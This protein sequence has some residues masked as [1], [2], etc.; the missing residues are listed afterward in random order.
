MTVQKSVNRMEFFDS[1]CHLDDDHFD[2]DRVD[3]LNRMHAAGV[4][5]CVCVGSDINTSERALAFAQK[6]SGVYAASGIH[7]HEAKSAQKDYLTRIETL[8]KNEKAVA[9]GEIGLDYYHDL[10]PRD[11][12]KQVFIEQMDL[13]CALSKPVIFH[14]R[15]AHGEMLEIFRARKK[16]L[17]RGII[18]CFSGSEE[19]AHEYIALGFYIS[20]A[21][22]LT[23]KNAVKLKKAA[24]SIPLNRLL[25][26]TDSPYLAPEPL[27]GHRNEPGNVLITCQQLAFLR[28][29]ELLDV[30]RI[31]T[32]NALAIYNITI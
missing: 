21:G 24:C 16:N 28:G 6:T 30:A 1:H 32:E 9:I 17:P 10:S 25:I 4:A 13:A 12:Q 15:D 14:I 3:T 8:L 11:I 27:R 19:V 31:T 18:H 29:I 7:P 2:L 22:S 23:Y 26:E 5:Y 20:F